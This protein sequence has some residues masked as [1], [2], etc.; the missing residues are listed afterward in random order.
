MEKEKYTKV[1]EALNETLDEFNQYLSIENKIPSVETNTFF[2]L[3]DK[4]WIGSNQINLGEVG[5][6]GVYIIVGEN[7]Q[8][9]DIN[10]YIGKASLSTIGKR[11]NSHLGKSYSNDKQCFIWEHLNCQLYR[12]YTINLSH[13]AFMSSALEEFMIDKMQEKFTLVNGTGNYA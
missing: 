11:L 2:Q 8:S 1:C 5:Y 9:H 6:S 12:V 4:C 10:L 3:E 7:L 13:L